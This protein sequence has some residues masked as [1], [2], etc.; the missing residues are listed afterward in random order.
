MAMCVGIWI[1]LLALHVQ[2][3]NGQMV[4]MDS[5]KSG[6]VGSQVE[7]RCIFINSNP[8]VKISQVT[9]QKLLNSTKQNVAIANPA[10][11]VSVLPPFKE[12]VSFKQAAVRHRTPSLEDTTIVF[13]NLQLSDEAA[14]ICEYTTFPAGNRENM[15]NLTVFARPMTRMTLTTPTIVARAQKRKMTVATCVSANGK[16][17]SVIKWETR[18]KGEATF[19]ETRNQNGTVT[20]RS[21]YVVVPSRETH[22]QR[23]TCIVTYR[24]EKITDSVVLNVQY[25][26]EV[27]IEGFDGN[28]YLNRQNVQLTCRADANPPVTIYQWKLLNG[29]LPSNVEI[30]NNTLFFKGPVTYDL[31][32]T[33]VCDATN[34]IG[35]R[36]GIVDVNITEK[37]MPQ[38]PPGGVIGILGG[39]VAIGLIIGVAVTVFMVHRRQQK[40][41]TE[42]D[43]DLIAV[44]AVADSCVTQAPEKPESPTRTDLPPA[45]KPAPP[46]PKKKNSDMKGHLTSDDIQVVHLDKEEEMQKL[47][48]Q[49]PYYDMAP[50]ESTPFT[51]K[52]DSGRRPEE[53]LNPAEYMG[54][55]RVCNMEHFPESQPAPAYPP[56]TF[57]PQH[58]YTQQPPNEPTY[59]NT[60]FPAPGPRAPFTFPKEQSV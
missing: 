21:N 49:P 8:P 39:V 37:P 18:L 41:R 34:G 9:W 1:L 47:P 44:A 35:T 16:P 29:S 36:T 31:A 46:P 32:G 51:D 50:S 58:P 60:S 15:V 43:N 59:S 12:R 11:G 53:L 48:L 4:Q 54:Y 2:A 27:K 57:L 26:P 28:W 10:L 42:T 6:F 25:E 7:L 30:K 33:Y 14:Y 23:L 22:K 45:H 40:T 56:V 17:P 5:S 19:Q 55:Q 13:S 52:P 38:G 3:G 20:V 24:N